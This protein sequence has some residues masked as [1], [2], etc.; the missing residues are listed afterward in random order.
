MNPLVA[1]AIA[2][3]QGAEL[4]PTILSPTLFIQ[5]RRPTPEEGPNSWAPVEEAVFLP[6]A[7]GEAFVVRMEAFFT[8]DPTRRPSEVPEALEVA[9][10]YL[11]EGGQITG[12]TLVP[13]HR[14]DHGQI[15]YGAPQEQYNALVRSARALSLQAHVASLWEGLDLDDPTGPA[16]IER[17]AMTLAAR[18]H[19][20]GIAHIEEGP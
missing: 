14:D 12:T 3:I 8:T 15:S 20:V 17:M 7:R 6:I 9:L 1:A 18:G 19:I 2:T 10:H 4:P 13:I 5:T 16:L 11:W